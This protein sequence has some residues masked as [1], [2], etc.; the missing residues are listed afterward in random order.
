VAPVV[1]PA[2]RVTTLPEATDP[3]EATLLAPE[4]MVSV[5][6]VAAGAAAACL[7]AMQRI[8]IKAAER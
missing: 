8:A 4:A 5:V 7:T 1:T 2:V 3:P 6:V